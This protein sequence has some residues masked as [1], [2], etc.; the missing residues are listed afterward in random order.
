[1]RSGTLIGLGGLCMTLVACGG[2]PPP[3]P[4]AANPATKPVAAA[5]APAP[6]PAPV[7]PAS[8]PAPLVPAPAVPQGGATAYDSKDRRDPFQPL[9]ITSGP[10][11][12]EVATTKLTGI[13]RS[14]RTT[15]ALV[16]AQDGIGYILKPG[17]TLGDGRLLEIGP[18]TAV[19]AVSAKAGSQS[20]RVV[21]KLAAN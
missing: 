8:Q 9:D 10:K 12:L 15:L 1:M 14:A 6:T 7:T 21:L 3:P 13:V 18:D 5:P 19:F 11:G 4:A 2:S 17:D 16:E 20:N